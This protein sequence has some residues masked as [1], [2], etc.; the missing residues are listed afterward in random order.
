MNTFDKISYHL[1]NLKDSADNYINDLLNEKE[2]II[3]DDDDL[4]T[5]I[6]KFTISNKK[7]NNNNNCIFITYNSTK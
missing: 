1:C 5:K 2:F 3:N 4:Y 7:K 6:N